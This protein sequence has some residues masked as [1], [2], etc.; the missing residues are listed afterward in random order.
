MNQAV[1]IPIALDRPVL[2][3]Q[4]R[5]ILER[6]ARVLD[7]DDRQCPWNKPPD[8]RILAMGVAEEVW[9]AQ[10]DTD[11]AG[12]IAAGAAGHI[13]LRLNGYFRRGLR[14]GLNIPCN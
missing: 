10:F 5:I 13:E 6:L 2:S 9:R 8:N 11:G 14:D 3:E 1:G 7:G 12:C 4:E